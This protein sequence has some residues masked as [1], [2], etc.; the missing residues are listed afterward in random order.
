VAAWG[1]V[2]AEN[3][4]RN[5]GTPLQQRLFAVTLSIKKPPKIWVQSQVPHGVVLLFCASSGK[6]KFRIVLLVVVYVCGIVVS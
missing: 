2:P 1:G 6:C 3:R 5:I 4:R